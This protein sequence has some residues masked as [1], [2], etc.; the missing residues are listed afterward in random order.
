[1]QR[2]I[3]LYACVQSMNKLIKNSERM[4]LK[5]V[6]CLFIL[7]VSYA[8]RERVRKLSVSLLFFFLTKN[9]AVSTKHR[10]TTRGNRERIRLSVCFSLR[11]SLWDTFTKVERT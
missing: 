11:S 6:T 2:K 7:D 1:M 3:P 4:I 5:T 9:S 10:E 8:F